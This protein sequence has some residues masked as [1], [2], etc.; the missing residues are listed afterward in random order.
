MKSENKGLEILVKDKA[1]EG[2][3][4]NI[5]RMENYKAEIKS[6]IAGGLG[7]AAIAAI[8]AGLTH[9]LGNSYFFSADP[10]SMN[11]MGKALNFALLHIG[12]FIAVGGAAATGLYAFNTAR[13]AV[14]L[15]KEKKNLKNALNSKL[16]D[17]DYLVKQT[18]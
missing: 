2:I 9:A 7:Y 16:K 8:S 3:S 13:N 11:L 5:S 4:E 12:Q 15:G 10:E 6:S 17:N 18:A 1:N 14:Y